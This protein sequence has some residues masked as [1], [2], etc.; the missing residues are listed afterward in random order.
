MQADDPEYQKV[1]ATL[2]ELD[3]GSLKPVFKEKRFRV[4]SHITRTK[5]V[6]DIGNS[7]HEFVFLSIRSWSF[8]FEQFLDLRRKK[9]G[10]LVA[11]ADK[12]RREDEMAIVDYI[13]SAQL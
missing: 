7:N 1:F 11:T 10:R 8:F 2:D 6:A 5:A 4:T 9:L 13:T 12:T 3:L